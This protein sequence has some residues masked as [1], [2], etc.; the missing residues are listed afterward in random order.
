MIDITAASEAVSIKSSWNKII[1][2]QKQNCSW[3]VTTLYSKFNVNLIWQHQ[4]HSFFLSVSFTSFPIFKKKIGVSFF[5]YTE[6]II[7][8]RK[9]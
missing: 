4:T 6:E 9:S 2:E 8:R 1:K 7:K 3:V 5:V